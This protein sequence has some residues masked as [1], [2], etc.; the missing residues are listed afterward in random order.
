MKRVRRLKMEDVEIAAA[1]SKEELDP[2]EIRMLEEGDANGNVAAPKTEEEIDDFMRRNH[3]L[4]HA[5]LRPYRGLDEYDDLYQEASIG[6]YRGLRTYDPNKGIKVT[7]YAFACG[8]NQV[9]MYLRR[10]T[11]KSR[12]ATVVSLDASIDPSDDRDTLLNKDLAAFDPLH[13]AE[14]MDETVH[15]NIQYAKAERIMREYLNET[16]RFVVSQFMKTIPQSQ[17]AK[18]LHTSQSEI[19]KILKTSICII[20]LKMQEEGI[21]ND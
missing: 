9:K 12:T 7:T 19:S 15:I 14:D 3:R 16:Q 1:A 20:R 6:F 4:I 8:R 13:P 10:A 5:I 21:S 2:D 11:A 18:I 17:T